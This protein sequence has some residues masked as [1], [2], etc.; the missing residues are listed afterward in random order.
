M[1]KK[2]F[3]RSAAFR[4]G[5]ALAATIP[6]LV[7]CAAGGGST[8]SGSTEA[9]GNGQIRFSSYG[10]PTKLQLRSSLADVY[11]KANPDVKVTFEG[12][13]TAD[14]WDK[15]ATQIAGGNAPDVINI[16]IARISQY[17]EKGALE[18][19]D[20]YIP[21]SI[22]TDPIDK[23]LLAQG[24]LDGKQYGIPVAMSMYATGFDATA[25]DKLGIAHPDGTWT[26]DSYADLA[27]EIHEKSGG[28]IYGSEDAS[29]DMSTLE[30]WLRTKGDVLWKD[31]K[32]AV[33]EKQ[34][35]DW[36]GYWSDLRASGGIV[37]ADVASQSKYGDW[38]N[39]PMVT[40][41]APLGHIY[42]AN[43][44]GGFQSL[45][46]DQIELT[47]PP[48]DKPGGKSG[49]F[50]SPSSYLSMS[51]KASDK[52]A[53]A[54]FINWFVNSK[55]SALTLR[56]ISGPPASSDGLDAILAAP[57]LTPAEKTVIDFT[58]KNLP[59]LQPAPPAAP[60]ASTQV[61][62]LFLKASQD[63]AFNKASAADASAQFLKDAAQAVTDAE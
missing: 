46:D 55:D 17:G 35:E 40:K 1:T 7:G 5:I 44:A 19:L 26:W 32:L 53:A 12:S 23:N 20:K 22:K 33:T 11:M 6:L 52:D 56:L 38:P 13:A 51:S 31:G 41:V 36:F 4:T 3:T 58:Q 42:T 57:D 10:D 47:M 25:L 45:T 49:T 16:D 34:L 59:D 54:K 43:L 18:P 37:P 2:K 24:Q 9:A 15:L 63:I 28:T 48:V 39:G 8:G 21:D 60:G 50:P 27:N 29:G 62:D 14:Y 30:V 61:A